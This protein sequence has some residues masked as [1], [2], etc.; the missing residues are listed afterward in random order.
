MDRADE[1]AQSALSFLMA[2]Q[3]INLRERPLPEE[4]IDQIDEDAPGLMPDCVAAILNQSRPG[5]AGAGP[6]NLTGMPR[7]AAPRLGRND[8]CSCGSGRKYK[9]CCARN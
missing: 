7:R 6:A 4:V 3:D 1:E 8:P 2:L 5:L 9:V